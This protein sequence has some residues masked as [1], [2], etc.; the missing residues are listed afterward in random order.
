MKEIDV[1]INVSGPD[2]SGKGYY[3]SAITHALESIGVTVLVQGGETHN[4]DKL[5]KTDDEIRSKLNGRSV[6]ILEQQT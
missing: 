5:T 1:I 2:K 3:I 4:K 6:L